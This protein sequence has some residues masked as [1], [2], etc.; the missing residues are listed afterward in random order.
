[1]SHEREEIIRL[2][3]IARDAGARQSAACEII[4]I[5]AKTLQRWS[6]PKNI[7]DDRLETQR[8]PANKMTA[9]ERQRVIKVANDP[10]YAELPPAQIVPKGP[11]KN[12]FVFYKGVNV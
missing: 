3:N 10:E 12:N 6:Q 8:E 4:G 1:M 7:S 2:I 5:S 11:R 9:L